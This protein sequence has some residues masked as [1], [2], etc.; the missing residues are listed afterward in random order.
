MQLLSG[1]SM[2]TPSKSSMEE[3]LGCFSSTVG[4]AISLDSLVLTWDQIKL[5]QAPLVLLSYCTNVSVIWAWYFPQPKIW[6]HFKLVTWNVSYTLPSRVR[7]EEIEST[8][9]WEVNLTELG[10]NLDLSGLLICWLRYNTTLMCSLLGDLCHQNG[11]SAFWL[12]SEAWV[13]NK[14]IQKQIGLS[15][16]CCQAPCQLSMSYPGSTKDRN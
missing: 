10:I 6:T 3:E 13:S 9:R 5:H 4:M 1:S 8:K 14:G 2:T 15:D 7:P 16:R 11:K 12:Q